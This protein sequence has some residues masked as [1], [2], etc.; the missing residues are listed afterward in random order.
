MNHPLEFIPAHSRKPVFLVLLAFTAVLF[1]VFRVLDAPLHTE[2]APNGIVSFELAG[3]ARQADA[4]LASWRQGSLLLSSV[5]GGNADIPNIPYLYASFGLGLDY[6]FM[7]A[8][9]LALSMGILLAAA[10]H[11]GILSKTGAWM[12]WAALAAAGFDAVEDY[13]L[14][15]MMRGELM[16]S[17]P[18]AAAACAIAKF[19]LLLAGILFALVCWLTPKR[20]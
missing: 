12:G 10:Q 14:L 9:A 11:R 2:A 3:T 8:Y 5:P 20:N 4:I 19:G 16:S 6:L 18:R 15:Q 13:A 7:P 1:G 17:W